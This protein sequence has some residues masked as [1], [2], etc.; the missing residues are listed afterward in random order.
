MLL[1]HGRRASLSSRLAFSF[2]SSGLH[3]LPAFPDGTP[4][5]SKSSAP[6]QTLGP[7]L[8]FR[9]LQIV[10]GKQ[11]TQ[12]EEPFSASLQVSP[13]PGTGLQVQASRV[14]Q[15]QSK[16]ARECPSPVVR[17]HTLHT[18]VFLFAAASPLLCLVCAE[19]PAG[20]RVP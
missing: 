8:E 17:T 19:V 11:V 6:L 2:A 18:P 15:R 3:P 14:V 4:R 20:L 13:P 1:L 12:G 9:T 10:H 7:A 5:A 16:F